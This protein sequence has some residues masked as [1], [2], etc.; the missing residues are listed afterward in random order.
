MRTSKRSCLGVRQEFPRSLQ[1][2]RRV[3]VFSTLGFGAY[4]LMR[5]LRA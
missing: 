3:A 2:V 5:Q 4:R 1:W